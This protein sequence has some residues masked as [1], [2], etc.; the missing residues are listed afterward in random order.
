MTTDK[1]TIEIEYIIKIGL[2]LKSYLEEFKIKEEQ[3]LSRSN[4]GL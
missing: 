1:D 4:I 2:K 3:F